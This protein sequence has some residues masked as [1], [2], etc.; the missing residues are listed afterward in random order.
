MVS[1]IRD[2]RWTPAARLGRWL[3][4]A[5]SLVGGLSW[6]LLVHASP[7]P[8]ADLVAGIVLAA[9]GLVLL[10][11]HRITLPPR[12]TALAMAVTALAGAGAGLLV[13]KTQTCCSYAYVVD[14]G[15]PLHWAQRAAFASDPD[16]A[17][18]MSG[19]ANW[20]VDLPSLAADLLI[21]AY[22]G[23][24]LVVIAVLVRRQRDGKE[25]SRSIRP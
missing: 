12:V 20:T 5:L 22:A 7:D 25:A 2:S 13:D 3:L 21:W 1:G 14:R 17:R 11:P 15:W 18:R 9:A 4:G 19:S 6:I 16:V 23:M 8:A 10:M 24:L